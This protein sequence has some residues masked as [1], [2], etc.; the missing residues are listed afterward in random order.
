MKDAN[1]VALGSGLGVIVGGFLGALAGQVFELDTPRKTGV[2]ALGAIFGAAAG[3]YVSTP[4]PLAVTIGPA[5]IEASM[6]TTPAT[7]TTASNTTT[8]PDTS[9]TASTDTTS[10]DTTASTDSTSTDTG[11]GTSG[12]AERFPAGSTTIIPATAKT[13][14]VSVTVPY[15]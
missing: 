13:P 8:S 5:Q 1:K 10:T 4:K 15:G 11:T 2:F 14:A 3:G 6:T 12:L 9:T 7:S